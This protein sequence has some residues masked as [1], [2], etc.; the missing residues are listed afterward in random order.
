[1]LVHY[2]I[3]LT[4]WTEAGPNLELTYFAIKLAIPRKTVNPKVNSVRNF[5]AKKIFK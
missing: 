5:V 3:A 1:M 4:V 2:S